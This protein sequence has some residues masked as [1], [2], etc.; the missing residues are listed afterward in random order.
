MPTH[1]ALLPLHI[2]FSSEDEFDTLASDVE[3][4]S[5]SDNWSGKEYWLGKKYFEFALAEQNLVESTVDES[6]PE[7]DVCTNLQQ[8]PGSID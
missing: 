1:S 5:T 6:A 4:M 2:D 3:V 8:P 7:L